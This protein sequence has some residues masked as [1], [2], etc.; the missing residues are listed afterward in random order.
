MGTFADYMIETDVG[1][2]SVSDAQSVDSM[3]AVGVAVRL[4][5]SPSGLYLLPPVS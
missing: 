5:F 3:H 1:E 4:Q 2:V